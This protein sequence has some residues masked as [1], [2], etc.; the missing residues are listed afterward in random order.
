MSDVVIPLLHSAALDRRVLREILT[1]A[2]LGSCVGGSGEE[3]N[4]GNIFKLVI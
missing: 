1:A 2:D 3:G 4:K